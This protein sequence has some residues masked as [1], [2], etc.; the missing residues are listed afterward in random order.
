VPIPR[1][2]VFLVAAWVMAFGAY[3]IYVARRPAEKD[4]ATD[5]PNFHRRGLY[6]RSRQAHLVMGILYL[7]LGGCLVAMGFGW[8]P[9]L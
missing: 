9:G 4:E 2:I 7:L 3:R 1:W 8:K 5:R 6:G